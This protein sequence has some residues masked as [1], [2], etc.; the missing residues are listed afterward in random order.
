[1]AAPRGGGTGGGGGGES[2]TWADAGRRH[3]RGHEP[4]QMFD[5]GVG[6]GRLHRRVGGLEGGGHDVWQVHHADEHLANGN[7]GEVRRGGSVLEDRDRLEE[8]YCNG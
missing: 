3:L 2:L 1:M 4:S 6:A 8:A 5:L 7:R